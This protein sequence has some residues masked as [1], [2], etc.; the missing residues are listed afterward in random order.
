MSVDLKPYASLPTSG[1]HRDRRH[2]ILFASPESVTEYDALR[3][4]RCC[5]CADVTFRN[6]SQLREHMRK[7]HDLFYCDICLEGL[8]LFPSEFKVYSRADLT[9]HRREG[10]PDD[11][12]YKPH[13]LCR[14][15]DHRFL[16]NDSL[17]EHLRQNH[18]WCHFCENDGRQDFYDNYDLL[19]RHFK[20]AHFLCEE[21]AC[22]QEKF[23]SVFRSK[24][25][26]QAHRSDIHAS[27]L[28]K[29]ERKK[30]KRLEV[31]FTFSRPSQGD[32][33]WEET[34]RRRG[35][36]RRGRRGGEGGGQR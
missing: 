36:G 32:S 33:G 21:G 17:H 10:D 31:G 25:D 27:G 16:D 34:V 14:F 35:G 26:L 6:F 20:E 9:R 18:F 13:P 7:T 2:G 3:Q 28:T 11:G 30:L 19:R 22:R 8:K 5:Q 23:T 15:C 24:I 29:S 1:V 12:S 4:I